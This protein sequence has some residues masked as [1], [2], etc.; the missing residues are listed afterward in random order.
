MALNPSIH[1]DSKGVFWLDWEPD[2]NA[3]AYD[4]ELS[5]QTGHVQAG[6]GQTAVKLGKP[7]QPFTVK[8]APAYAQTYEAVSYPEGPTGPT[9]PTGPSGPTGSTGPTGPQPGT[10]LPKYGWCPGAASG[11]WDDATHAWV[12]AKGKECAQGESFAYRVNG[13]PGARTDRDIMGCWANGMTPYLAVGGTNRS[14]ST[15]APTWLAS[16]VQH[17]KSL[18][19]NWAANHGGIRPPVVYTGPNEPDLNGWD[20]TTLA[21]HQVS[22]Y[23]VIKANDKDVL[24]GY[25]AIWKGSPNAFANWQPYIKQAAAIAKGKFDFFPGHFYDDPAQATVANAGW[26]CWNWWF[27][28]YGGHAGQTAEDILQAAGINVPIVN[29][30]SGGKNADPEFTNK[31]LRLLDQTKQGPCGMTIIYCVLPDVPGYNYLLNANRT[32]RPCYQPFKAFM[33]TV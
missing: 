29:D 18:R 33:A 16:W 27:K 6:K 13:T 11:S 28:R 10:V 31:C 4:I 15:A 7:A 17:I 9:G 12:M 24:V 2:D 22:I 21:K 30:E 20:A 5:W 26:N 25:A 19:D 23:D 3:I 32:E 8:V 14:P 1:Q